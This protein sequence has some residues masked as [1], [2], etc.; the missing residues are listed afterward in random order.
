MKQVFIQVLSYYMVLQKNT[1]ILFQGD[2]ITDAFRR[3]EEPNIS[4]QMGAGYALLV[5]A[6]LLRNHPLH[7]F[8]FL[9][10]GVSGHPVS[11]LLARW[12]VDCLALKPDFLSVLAGVNDTLQAI[13]LEKTQKSYRE[14]LRL[15]KDSLGEIK[16]LLCE[17][18]LLPCG[19]V[20]EI[21]IVDLKARQEL[22]RSLA[23][24]FGAGYLPLQSIFDE[25]TK[26]AP[27]EHWA[28]DGIHPTAA[29]A[30]LISEAWLREV[31]VA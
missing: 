23:A 8:R 2:S 31:W 7:G 5:A 26:V 21:Q 19:E 4:Y 27:P 9:N 10:R 6:E 12:D 29:G 22:V 18:F 24:E 13:P 17:P 1:S 15:T 3:P 28:Y 14:I 16:I 11:S 20:T 25:A 30:K